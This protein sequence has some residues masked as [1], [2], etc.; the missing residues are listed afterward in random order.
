VTA[1]PHE[2][3]D[4]L[5]ITPLQSATFKVGVATGTIGVVALVVAFFISSRL[6]PE[7]LA[8]VAASLRVVKLLGGGALVLSAAAFVA[9]G[10]AY[11]F[12][13]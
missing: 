7:T 10:F 3:R 2:T 11:R 8:D 6:T 1:G 13:R 9:Y 5:R 4:E 12:N